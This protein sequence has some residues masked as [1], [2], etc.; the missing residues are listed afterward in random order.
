[1]GIKKKRIRLALKRARLAEAANPKIEAENS[2]VLEELKKEPEVPKKEELNEPPKPVLEK[3]ETKK[4]TVP[5][6]PRKRVATR[7]KKPSS[8]K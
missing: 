5:K 7:R 6:S 1:M 3:T 2:V 4:T 8:S